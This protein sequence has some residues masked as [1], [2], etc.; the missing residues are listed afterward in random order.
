[1]GAFKLLLFPRLITTHLL[2]Y[3]SLPLFA[4]PPDSRFV[5]CGLQADMR[6]AMER[7][8]PTVN[9]KDLDKLKKFTDDF[10]QEG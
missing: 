1:M 5:V 10:G 8:K 4:F 3:S 7:Q 2:F 9:E 6:C